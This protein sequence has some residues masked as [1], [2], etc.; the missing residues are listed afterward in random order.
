MIYFEISTFGFE[1]WHCIL[2]WTHEEYTSR[3]K[4]P[5]V[6]WPHQ[7]RDGRKTVCQSHVWSLVGGIQQKKGW[8]KKNNKKGLLTGESLMD[9]GRGSA[10][11]IYKINSYF[12]ITYSDACESVVVTQC[13]YARIVHT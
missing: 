10:L 3:N 13:V 7:A 4:H 6:L 5:Q 2:G 12:T 9:S 1:T 8:N 11:L